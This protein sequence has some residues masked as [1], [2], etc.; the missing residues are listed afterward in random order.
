MSWETIIGLE[1][2]VQLSTKTKIFSSAS[3][4]FGNEQNSQANEIDLALPGTLPVLNKAA[5]EYAI[6]FGLAIDAEINNESVFER[7]N[8]FYPD[9]PKGYQTTQLEKPIV[10]KGS[11]PITLSDGII[12]LT[13]LSRII[14]PDIEEILRKNINHGAIVMALNRLS[15]NLEFQHTQKIARVVKK[16]GDIT[17]RSNLT[18][19]N[20]KI[21]ESLM[22]KQADVLKNFKNSNNNFYS[23]SRGVDECNI[24]VSENLRT[25]VEENFEGETLIKKTDKLSAISFKLPQENVSVPGIYYYVFQKLSWDG[26]NIS[27]VISTSNEFTILVSEREVDNAF[28]VINSL[29]N[30]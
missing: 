8:Y 12:N 21:S 18:D 29:K 5:L 14:K 26:I 11:V 2:H 17:V 4:E 20:F 28:S 15:V 10:G 9:L 6:M 1:V 3:T 23:S 25:L 7:K 27:Q 19:Y 24:V 30:I 22:I 13:S 16:I